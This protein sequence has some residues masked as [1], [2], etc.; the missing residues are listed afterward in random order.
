MSDNESN[1]QS[2]IDEFGD[3][4]IPA[5]KTDD[6]NNTKRALLDSLLEESRSYSSGSDYA[7]LLE[8]VSRMRN[9]APF[10]AMLLDKQKP[11]ITYA[12]SEQ[13]WKV[14]FKRGVKPDSRPLVIMWPFSPVAFVYDVLDTYD[15]NN[16]GETGLPKNL[17]T[18]FASGSI[19]KEQMDKFATSLEKK[20][21]ELVYVD[22]GDAKAGLIQKLVHSKKFRYQIKIN[23]NHTIAVQFS[24]LVH[25]LAHL[26]LGHLG[27]DKDV[28]AP[29]RR[30]LSHTEQ[31]IEAESVAYIVCS[32]NGVKVESQKYLSGYINHSFK[33]ESLEISQ[34]LLSAGKIET[35]FGLSGKM[36]LQSDKAS[37]ADEFPLNLTETIE[38]RTYRDFK[39]S[40]GHAKENSVLVGI[41]MITQL[42]S[43]ERE[44]RKRLEKML[45]MHKLEVHSVNSLVSWR[46]LYSDQR[47]LADIAN[48]LLDD[49]A[50][51]YR[52]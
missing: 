43:H 29:K 15:L 45:A 35:F 4:C 44:V 19:T 2:L 13:D 49:V 47:S 12:S 21:I 26:T 41:E 24:T 37:T 28:P 1:Q 7:N 18:F 9:V 46:R 27:R 31:E 33:K 36:K 32:R 23:R 17:T 42:Y 39:I 38:T 20:K 34:I 6:T 14:R 10:N 50:S 3:I 16:P 11:G 30:F 8:T 22:T 48:S 5:S 25:E 51:L 52:E 40:V